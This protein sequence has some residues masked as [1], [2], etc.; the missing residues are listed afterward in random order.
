MHYDAYLPSLGAYTALLYGTPATPLFQAA[1]IE[2]I[3]SSTQQL[4]TGKNQQFP[5]K[6]ACVKT[7]SAKTFGTFDA[8]WGDNVVCRSL[9]VILAK[10]RPDVSKSKSRKAVVWT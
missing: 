7:L 5:T 4:C 3:C 6:E 2:Q 1:T 10:L 9:H 8:A